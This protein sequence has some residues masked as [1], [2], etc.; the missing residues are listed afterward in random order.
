MQVFQEHTSAVTG[1]FLD[2][3][4]FHVSVHGPRTRR[5]CPSLLYTAYL[6]GAQA[7]LAHHA[8]ALLALALRAI[9]QT[10]GSP[11][12]DRVMHA[13]QAEVLLAYYFLH[14]ARILEAQ[15]H[16]CAAVSLVFSAGLHRGRREQERAGV[17]P[18]A[19]DAV[20]EGER[21]HAF[22]T[23][24]TLNNVV[25]GATGSQSNISYTAPSARIDAPWPLN[26]EQYSTV[27]GPFLFFSVFLS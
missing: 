16:T 22:W 24:L 5:P 11:H 9:P 19:G 2:A 1:F 15:Y 26:L 6:W 25:A 23:V 27:R 4:R 8:P 21:V 3:S 17:L 7:D 10:L 12:P 13:V 18:P 14:N 20:E